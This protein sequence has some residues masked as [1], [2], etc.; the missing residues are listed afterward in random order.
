VPGA[1]H[2]YLGEPA[3]AAGAFAWNA[4]F[5]WAT[6]ESFRDRR[7]GPGA[8][9]ATVETIFYGGAVYGAVSG[10]MRHRR[11]ARRLEAAELERRFGLVVAPRA[12][13]VRGGF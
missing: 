1:G 2:L 12:L 13:A 4:V 9:L 6:V 5:L 10:A 11:D 7:P 3:V 8:A